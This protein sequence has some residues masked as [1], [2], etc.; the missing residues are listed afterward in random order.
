MDT[1]PPGKGTITGI[2]SLAFTL[3]L[4]AKTIEVFNPFQRNGDTK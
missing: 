3:R 2:Q 4:D 1:G